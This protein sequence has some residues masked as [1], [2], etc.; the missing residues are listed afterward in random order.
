M[1]AGACLPGTFIN[2]QTPTQCD[3]CP[4]GTY[5]DT[6]WQISCNQCPA[7]S[8]TSNTGS[9]YLSDCNGKIT[10]MTVIVYCHSTLVYI[11]KILTFFERILLNYKC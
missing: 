6:K 7:G 5:Q 1:Y 10:R 11:I 8:T 9:V 2:S 3:P 4:I